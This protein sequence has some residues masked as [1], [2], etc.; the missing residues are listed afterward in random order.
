M[1]KLKLIGLVEPV[2]PSAQEAFEEW[3]L[4]SHIEDISHAPGVIRATVHRLLKPY[5]ETD[6]PQY[7]TIYEFDTEEVGDA[8]EALQTYMNH[9]T[10]PGHRPSN[11][12]SRILSAGWYR[13]ERS[14]SSKD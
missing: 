13:V 10:W 1:S 12:S 4:G 14:F 7:V 3:Y 6:P 5:K 2:D 8:A 11:G 9:P